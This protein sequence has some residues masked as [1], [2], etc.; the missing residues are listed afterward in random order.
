MERGKGRSEGGGKR[1]SEETS[2]K[3][4]RL[5]N[6]HV[7]GRQREAVIIMQGVGT[8]ADGAADTAQKRLGSAKQC[9]DT[10]FSSDRGGA[11]RVK[12]SGGGLLRN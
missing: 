1:Q 9:L 12:H 3:R 4:P 6:N 10:A 2:D 11:E 8:K 5:S 7:A